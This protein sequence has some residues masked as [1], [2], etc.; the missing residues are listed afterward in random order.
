LKNKKS[1]KLNTSD[2]SLLKTEKNMQNGSFTEKL[3]TSQN[4]MFSQKKGA[5][6]HPPNS[7][8]IALKKEKK[9]TETHCVLSLTTTRNI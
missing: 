7:S 6:I 1:Y 3:E 9:T 4:G 8:Q 5:Q 2:H